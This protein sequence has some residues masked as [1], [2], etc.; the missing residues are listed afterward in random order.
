M[1]NVQLIRKPLRTAVPNTSV[2]PTGKTVFF[3]NC[4]YHSIKKHYIIWLFTL[5]YLIIYAFKNTLRST[6]TLCNVVLCAS[7]FTVF[8]VSF[9]LFLLF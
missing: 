8:Q 3:A 2:A 4:F 7:P 1:Q 9:F 5:H 6:E